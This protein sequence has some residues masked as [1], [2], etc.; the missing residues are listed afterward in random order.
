M[1]EAMKRKD[2]DPAEESPAEGTNV[3]VFMW[4]TVTEKKY[5]VE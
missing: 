2:G 3:S 5:E 1:L 4:P